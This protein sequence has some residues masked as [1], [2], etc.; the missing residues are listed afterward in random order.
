VLQYKFKQVKIIGVLHTLLY[1][2]Y[3]VILY[4]ETEGENGTNYLM[5]WPFI[6]SFFEILQ[7]I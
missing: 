1:I 5:P 7:I 3:L 2:A 4:Q 6:H